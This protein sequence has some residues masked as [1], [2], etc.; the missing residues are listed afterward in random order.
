MTRTA[1]IVREQQK[2][3]TQTPE[4]WAVVFHNDNV[5]TVEFVMFTLMHVFEKNPKEALELTMQVHQEG[6]GIVLITTHEIAEQKQAECLELAEL[7]GYP[8]KVTI[9]PY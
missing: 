1:E 6:Y 9:Q 4:Q 3:F 5:T 7:N 8:F 2:V